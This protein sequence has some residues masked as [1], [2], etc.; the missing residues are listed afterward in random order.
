[1]LPG[2]SARHARGP[3]TRRG[4]LG[5]VR[6]GVRAGLGARGA[7]APGAVRTVV[8][9]AGGARPAGA[10]VAG[11]ARPGAL[12]VAVAALGLAA[13]LGTGAAVQGLPGGADPGVAGSRVAGEVGAASGA[14]DVAT[15]RAA[16][17]RPSTERAPGP[18]PAASGEP[19]AASVAEVGAAA[20]L[21]ALAERLE[22]AAGG[23]PGDVR[24]L[25]LPTVVPRDTVGPVWLSPTDRADGLLSVEVLESG[26]GVL[27]VVPGS[28][29]APGTAPVTSVRVEVEQGLAVDGAAF[30][31]VVMA[32]LNDPRGWG[33]Q[34]AV[35]FARTD[36]PADVRVVLAS[37]ATVDAMCAPLPTAGQVS[38]GRDG[39][40]VLNLRRWVEA[41]GEFADRHLY[42]QYLVNHEVGH[43]LGHTHEECPG[44]GQ[45]APIMQ[46][47]SYRV[48]PCTPNGWPFP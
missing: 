38:C 7:A 30:A 39:H 21:A 32:T 23:L 45:P 47:Q 41:T 36:G 28:S 3:R 44:A 17:T 22:A 31:G 11:G 2:T 14:T 8:P 34:G 27:D 42:R 33:A 4:V 15:A 26:S 10:P 25:P 12:A 16:L 24:P 29:P 35:T 6:A 46:Q 40:A 37:P 19:A 5:G 9:V 1:M 20:E 18:V 43:L 48:A 13:G